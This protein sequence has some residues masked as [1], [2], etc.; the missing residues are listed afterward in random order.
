MEFSGCTDYLIAMLPLDEHSCQDQIF[1]MVFFNLI[2]VN[3]Y[4]VKSL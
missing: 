3:F 1:V 4:T 2:F